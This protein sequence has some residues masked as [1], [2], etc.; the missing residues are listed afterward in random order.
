MGYTL[1]SLPPCLPVFKPGVSHTPLTRYEAAATVDDI[2][3]SARPYA[4]VVHCEGWTPDL[5]RAVT[6][7]SLLI[8]SAVK[9]S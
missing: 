1:L 2:I 4:W 9:L 6:H 3:R 8:W 5:R 7:A